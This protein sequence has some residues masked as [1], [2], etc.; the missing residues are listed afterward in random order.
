MI[1]KKGVSKEESSNKL[2]LNNRTVNDSMISFMWDP[3]L[4]KFYKETLPG[5]T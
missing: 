5:A 3:K 1:S 4:D 2:L